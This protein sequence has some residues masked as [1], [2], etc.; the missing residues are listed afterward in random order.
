ML[1]GIFVLSLLNF[2]REPSQEIFG[3]YETNYKEALRDHLHKW[4]LKIEK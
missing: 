4:T 3:K 2:C 1:A